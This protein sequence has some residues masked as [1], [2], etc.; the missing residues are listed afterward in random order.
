[1]NELKQASTGPSGPVEESSQSTESDY[2]GRKH[3][4]TIAD[5]LRILEE[6]DGCKHGELGALL[7]R[8]GLYHPT[9][10][11]WRK[12]RD[13][14]GEKGLISDKDKRP[15]YNELAK[16]KRE[17]KRLKLKLERT[18]GLIALQKKALEL[19]ESLSQDDESE[20]AS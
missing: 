1:M 18:E 17:N 14:M 11:K 16:V 20:E 4:H 19:L 13:T 12:W 15:V 9:I 10:V 2:V 7:R 6:A 5:R 3:K 8:E